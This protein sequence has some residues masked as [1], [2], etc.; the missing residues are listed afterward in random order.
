MNSRKSFKFLAVAVVAALA[1]PLAV[2]IYLSGMVDGVAGFLGDDGGLLGNASGGRAKAS[3]PVALMEQPWG[4]HGTSRTR[5]ATLP[6][7]V[8]NAPQVAGNGPLA[9]NSLAWNQAGYRG[10]GIKV[11]IIDGGFESVRSLM[12][13]E[14]PTT[15]M[16][17]C[18]T[19][20]GIFTNDL[21]DCEVDGDHG[22]RVAEAV[23]DI[24]PE[25]TLYIASPSEWADLSDA[26]D[27]MISE[28]VS[29]INQSIGWAYDGPG[30]GTSP[31]GA[32]PLQ[33]VD[34]AVEN[35]IVWVNAA[36]NDARTTWFGAFADANR[37]GFMEFD[38]ADFANV[39]S[40]EAGDLVAVQLR[41][42]DSWGAA[43]RD[44]DLYLYDVQ[45]NRPLLSSRNI[46]D[47]GPGQDPYEFFEYR[48]TK[49]GQAYIAVLNPL[50]GAA[51]EWV[52]LVVSG[53]VDSIEHA[54]GRHSIA[55]PAESINPG[56][57]AVGAA[58]WDDVETIWSDSSLGPTLGDRV[59]PDLVGANCGASALPPRQEAGDDSCGTSQAAA[60][61]AGLAALVRQRFPEFGP[62]QTANYLRQTAE[63][64]EAPDPNNTWGHG[65]ARLPALDEPLPPQPEPM[66]PTDACLSDLGTLAR[67]D[68]KHRLGTWSD[69]CPSASKDGSYARYY[70]FTLG[71]RMPVQINLSSEQD[72][73]LFLLQG[74]GRDGAVV[75][76]ND[77]VTPPTDTNSRISATLDA[78]TYTIEATTYNSGTTGEFTLSINVPEGTPPPP[79]GNCSVNLG[80]ITGT[81]SRDG[82][83]TVNCDSV[84]RDG[85]YARFYTFTLEQ[86]AEVQIDLISQQDPYLFLLHGAG[87][88][89]TVVAENDDVI[90]ITDTNSQIATTL[91]AGVYTVEA[92]T[93]AAGVT[94]E[95]TLSINVPEGTSPPPTGNCSVNL[96]RITG[97]VSRDG[98]WTVNC[99]SVNRDGRYARFY[100]FTLEQPAEVQIDLISQQDPYLF[101]LHGAGT[102]GTV[103]AENDDV[104][105]ITDTNSQIATTLDAGVYTVE[106]TTFS[107]GATGDYTLTITPGGAADRGALVALYNATNGDDWRNNDNWLSSR[108]VSHWYGV[109]TDPYDRV[110]EL[111][112]RYNQLTGEIPPE[113]G[114]L[115]NLERLYLDYNRLRGE[116]PPGLGNLVNLERLYLNYNALGGEIPPELGRLGNLERLGLRKNVLEGE[117]PP[118]LG[119]MSKLERLYL[120]A[121][122]LTGALPSE[123]GNL[124]ALKELSIEGNHL[125]GELPPQLGNLTSLQRLCLFGNQL[126]GEIPEELGNL[127]SLR[128]LDIAGNQLNGKIPRQLGNLSY[129]THLTLWGNQLVGEIPPE[130]GN[131][132]GLIWLH[133]RGNQLS[134]EV[135]PQLGS[136]G[137]L[138]RL[139]LGSNQLTGEIP[140]QLGSLASLTQLSLAH[141]HLSGEIP[142]QLGILDNLGYLR[143]AGNQLAGCVPASLQDVADNEL[144]ELGLPF[145]AT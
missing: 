55:N 114:N 86:P 67:G 107:E 120:D 57:L 84:N 103:V 7:P 116:I 141:N 117:I 74:A 104:I 98:T 17:R 75:T 70:S 13:T 25:V 138:L 140:P 23:I 97:T 88:D 56:L 109:I 76:E 34:R 126:G 5:G 18:Y 33:T 9:H 142:A 124:S 65:F 139:N 73:Y 135:P 115:T 131:L 89:G 35:G 99:D 127:S 90:H 51:P 94:G 125:D 46:Q 91:D 22:T 61:V 42:D 37:D 20:Y 144:D 36:G 93:Y 132:S 30:D 8:R 92:T 85:R 79:T 123:L 39:M 69:N 10:Q 64:R 137:N 48:V 47:G 11:G 12:G 44:L 59:K 26:V 15:V 134:G 128:E 101:L 83:W 87:T 54:T 24:A 106:A 119:E 118:E 31:H 29:V 130:L 110:A 6:Q 62:E 40:H 28:G 19:D 77:D 52:Q 112:L 32:G 21:A 136:L 129:L 121:N 133:L 82:T 145:C 41:W 96:G 45:T 63:Q 4:Q 100:T 16:A 72:P 68:A 122:R 81:V 14:L 102:D 60:H 58:P 113:L 1:L 78:G 27:W 53:D 49:G 95:F 2:A 143:L 105:H 71:Q 43:S 66:P 50:R 3:A 108:H 38:G 80:R 111:H